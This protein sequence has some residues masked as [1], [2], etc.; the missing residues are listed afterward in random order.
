MQEAIEKLSAVQEDG[1]QKKSQLIDLLAQRS[2]LTLR[3][4][5]VVCLGMSVKF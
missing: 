2:L 4:Q 3:Q 1:D 5:V